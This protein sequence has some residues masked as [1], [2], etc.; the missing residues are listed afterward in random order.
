MFDFDAFADLTGSFNT[1]IGQNALVTGASLAATGMAVSTI[2][3]LASSKPQP[4]QDPELKLPKA[5]LK[6]SLLGMMM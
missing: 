6:M 4:K 3:D 2:F 5:M 1:A